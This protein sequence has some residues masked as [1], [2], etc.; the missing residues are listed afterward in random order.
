LAL[1]VAIPGLIPGSFQDV[2][3]F[4]FIVLFVG[5]FVVMA[6]VT[7]ILSVVRWSVGWQIK[8]VQGGLLDEG[9][10]IQFNTK[11]LIVLLTLY[12]LALGIFFSLKFGPDNPPSPDY[13]QTVSG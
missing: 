9:R 12:S 7:L 5:A 1:V 11:Y 6:A 10:P 3:Q 13:S 4:E 2:E 8:P